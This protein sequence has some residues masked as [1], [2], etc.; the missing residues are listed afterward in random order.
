MLSKHT[1]IHLIIQVSLLLLYGVV[2]YSQETNYFTLVSYG[3]P[4]DKSELTDYSL[5]KLKILSG[6]N[7]DILDVYFPGKGN[8]VTDN[9][10][11]LFPIGRSD[12]TIINKYYHFRIESRAHWLTFANKKWDPMAEINL[13]WDLPY[14]GVELGYV[15]S[16]KGLNK[17]AGL[18]GIFLNFN[19]GVNSV[20]SLR[21]QA[22]LKA[23]EIAKRANNINLAPLEQRMQ[24]A[25]TNLKDG[26]NRVVGIN[27]ELYGLDDKYKKKDCSK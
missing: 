4:Y 27:K 13:C 17:K 22:K 5:S 7:F 6:P 18:N 25:S 21:T 12:L 2:G 19:L 23:K 26:K 9:Y 15:V 10:Y 16:K 14:V 11:S 20:N 24:K 1:T 3:I 8:N